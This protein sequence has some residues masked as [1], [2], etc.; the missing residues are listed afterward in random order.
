[1]Q[2]YARKPM[3]VSGRFGVQQYGINGNL[4]RVV[5]QVAPNGTYI[6]HLDAFSTK[7]DAAFAALLSSEEDDIG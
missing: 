1:M 3:S 6:H 2:D 4:W 7:E 5:E